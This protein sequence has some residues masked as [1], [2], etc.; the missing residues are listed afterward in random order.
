MIRRLLFQLLVGG[1]AQSDPISDVSN[2]SKKK[3]RKK[4]MSVECSASN[5]DKDD[6]KTDVKLSKPSFADLVSA[7][8][9]V[10]LYEHKCYRDETGFKR[11][12][13][14]CIL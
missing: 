5:E 7:A 12:W 14:M 1:K 4:K 13:K 9:R 8:P 6:V 3:K 2:T 10:R 11:W